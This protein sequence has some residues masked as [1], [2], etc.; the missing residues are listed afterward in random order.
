MLRIQPAITSLSQPFFD[1]CRAG[2]LRLQ[3]CEGCGH[4]Q[5]YPRIVCTACGGSVLRWLVACGQGRIASFTVVH[6][7]ISP[8]YDVPYVVALVDLVEGPRLM[9]HI[10]GAPTE[11]IAVGAPVT[12]TFAAW[13]DTVVMPVFRLAS[14][15][16]VIEE[17]EA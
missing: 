7:A 9:S 6:R 5:F 1:G 13:S 3:R 10:V 11:N 17:V 14:S 2:E 8:A 4:W 16:G 12:V 15:A